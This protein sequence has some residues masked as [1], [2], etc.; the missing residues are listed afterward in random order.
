MDR[1]SHIFT[2]ITISVQ[3]LTIKYCVELF[4]CQSVL[5]PNI[6]CHYFSQSNYQALLAGLSTEQQLAQTYMF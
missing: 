2:Q 1:T 6:L 5:K 3:A 4:G